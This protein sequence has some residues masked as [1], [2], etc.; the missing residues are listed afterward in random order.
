M[1]LRTAEI[2]TDLRDTKSSNMGN[3][4]WQLCQY[5]WWQL[6]YFFSNNTLPRHNPHIMKFILLKCTIKWCL[7]YSELYNSSL[8]ALFEGKWFF[9][10]CG[11]QTLIHSLL[12]GQ[13]FFPKSNPECSTNFLKHWSLWKS[14]KWAFRVT[15]WN[16]SFFFFS[17][18]SFV[19][20]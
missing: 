6:W 12:F 16:V 9:S 18:F 19:G 13:L 15:P 14:S 5:S 2:H 4:I 7:V 3:L 8:S 1:E 20:Y 11:S 17:F 10:V